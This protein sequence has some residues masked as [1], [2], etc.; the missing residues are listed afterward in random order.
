MLF[1]VT[2]WLTENGMPKENIHMEVFFRSQIDERR[3][4]MSAQRAAAGEKPSPFKIGRSPT[5]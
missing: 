2:D 3:K 4:Q 1:E 5:S